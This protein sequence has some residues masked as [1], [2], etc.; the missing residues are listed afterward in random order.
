M[1]R[2][3][4]YNKNRDKFFKNLSNDNLENLIHRYTKITLLQRIKNKIRSLLSKIKRKLL[5]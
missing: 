1:I 4:G 2:P 3:V 5:K